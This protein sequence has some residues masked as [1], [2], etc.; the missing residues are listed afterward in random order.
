M[1]TNVKSEIMQ[2]I[3]KGDKPPLTFF[4]STSDDKKF[5]QI[6]N[7]STKTTASDHAN[8]S[9]RDTVE[10]EWCARETETKSVV[11]VIIILGRD[12][13]AKHPAKTL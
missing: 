12:V 9:V 11:P 6:I 2:Q 10:I 8:N 3:D 13:C 1:P 5:I 7:H 4:L